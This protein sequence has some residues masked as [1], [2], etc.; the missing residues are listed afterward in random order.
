M[1]DKKKIPVLIV[2]DIES[3]EPDE[4]Y[5]LDRP[6][7]FASMF[8]SNLRHNTEK[9]KIL[10]FCV[11]EFTKDQWRLAELSGLSFGGDITPK[12]VQEYDRL[13]KKVG[14]HKTRVWETI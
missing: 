12:Q 7:Q 6:G 1:K 2:H 13:I 3:G 8:F 9:N 14:K 11:D 10:H 5:R 4:V